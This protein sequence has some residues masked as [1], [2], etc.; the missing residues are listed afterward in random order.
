MISADYNQG[1]FV[2]VNYLGNFEKY[3]QYLVDFNSEI[4]I[5]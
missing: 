4:Q 5:F 1:Y 3:Y 2:K